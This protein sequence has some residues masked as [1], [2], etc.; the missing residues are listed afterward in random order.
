M[1]RVIVAI[2]SLLMIVVFQNCSDVQ[3]GNTDTSLAKANIDTGE[4]LMPD[5]SGLEDP[6]IVDEDV[7]PLP[8]EDQPP[9]PEEYDDPPEHHNHGHNGNGRCQDDDDEDTADNGEL[10]YT[11]VLE[12]P[13]N[14]ER[15]ALVEF[16]LD[17][18]R[19]T[20]SQVC[21]SRAACEQIISQV[22]SVKKAK[23]SRGQCQGNRHMVRLTDEMVQAEVDELLN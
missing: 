22:F 2:S 16:S 4:V 18:Q 15:V 5:G 9:P 19:A 20:P 3:F 1:Q 11:C 23:R 17:S 13:G 21:M 12:G 8:P 7:P 14:S 6:V 10:L